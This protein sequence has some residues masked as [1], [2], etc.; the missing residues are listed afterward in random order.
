MPQQLIIN[1]LGAASVDSLSILTGCISDHDCNILDSRHA[2]YGTDFSLTMII[3][4]NTSSVTLLELD[5]S[6]VCMEHDLLCLMKRTSGHQKQ[7]ISQIIQLNFSGLDSYGL[8]QKVTSTIAACGLSVSA[9]R[10]KTE[11]SQVKGA[12]NTQ[13]V[14]CKMILSAP[15][16]LDLAA[17]DKAI[18]DLLHNLGLH[19]QISHNTQKESHEYIES[20]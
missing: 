17:F 8:M 14:V 15:K 9:V 10:Q 11:S 19:G 7:N 4:G 6:R 2:L 18:K 5:L 3:S 12:T 16:E 20:W 13:N 1:V